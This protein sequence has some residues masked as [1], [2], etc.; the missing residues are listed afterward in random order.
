MSVISL[1]PLSEFSARVADIL[2][3]VC[4]QRHLLS[5]PRDE[6]GTANAMIMVGHSEYQVSFAIRVTPHCAMQLSALL[7][8]HTFQG[9]MFREQGRFYANAWCESGLFITTEQELLWNIQT[10]VEIGNIEPSAHK[11]LDE[12]LGKIERVDTLWRTYLFAETKRM[13]SVR[14]K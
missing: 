8:I 5:L 2:E 12:F 14:I 7:K 6:D 1:R 4:N 11:I 3:M 9:G 13:Q 10:A